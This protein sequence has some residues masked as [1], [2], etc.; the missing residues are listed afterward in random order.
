MVGHLGDYALGP[1]RSVLLHGVFGWAAGVAV[2]HA[3][4][5]LEGG[6]GVGV[7]GGVE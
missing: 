2:G 3:G 5:V 6:V 7:A 1:G 4:A